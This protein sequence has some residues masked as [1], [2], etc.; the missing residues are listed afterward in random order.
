MIN[1][2]EN[3]I[4]APYTT[5]KIGGPAKYFVEVQNENELKE[6]LD[7]ALKNKLAFFVLGGGSNVLVSDQGFDGL[8]IQFK[9]TEC[10]VID[11]KIECGAGMSLT[12][13]VGLTAENYL[14]GL[15]WAAG[16]PGTLGGAIRGNAG[17]FDGDM[18]SL[19]ENVKV[20]STEKNDN[21]KCK[22]FSISECEFEYRSSIFKRKNN[23]IIISAIL[24]LAKGDRT[25]I[26]K[27]INEIIEKRSQIHPR[28][29]ASA[30][31]FFINPLVDDPA[32]LEKFEKDSG[33]RFPDN[34]IPAGW[35]I[36]EAGLV[37]KQ[38]GGAMISEKHSN[39]IVNTG[40]A[41]AEDVIM[42][43]SLIKQKVR[44]ELGIQLVEEVKF[45]GF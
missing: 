45:L 27:K 39:F 20:F 5:F 13:L 28:G 26:Q 19:I 15:E 32:F 6:S 22:N 10:K 1:V 34:M 18:Q 30:G 23:L 8:V 36:Q 29:N 9:N 7:Y 14:T 21:F 43:A 2:Q 3:V 40:K 31:S 33:K 37:G 11:T 12:K 38:I 16:I 42:L 35:L 41:T 4:L 24:K 25:E 17:A 44:N